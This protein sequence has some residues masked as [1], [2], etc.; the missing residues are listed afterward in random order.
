MSQEAPDFFV[1]EQPP[2]SG[3]PTSVPQ[4][5]PADQFL[6][7]IRKTV[8]NPEIVDLTAAEI[9]KRSRASWREIG[10]RLAEMAN[11]A[12]GQTDRD[13]F[14]GYLDVSL[15]VWELL[16]EAHRKKWQAIVKESI[17]AYAET[18][19]T[20]AAQAMYRFKEERYRINKTV[21]I[22]HRQGVIYDAEKD[23]GPR[24]LDDMLRIFRPEDFNAFG[25]AVERA[26]HGRSTISF[27]DLRNPEAAGN[28]KTT[29]GDD[30]KKTGKRTNG[31]TIAA[32]PDEA[33]SA[34]AESFVE[35]GLLTWTKTDGL[36]RVKS[37]EFMALDFSS[38]YAVQ[39]ASNVLTGEEEPPVKNRIRSLDDL[40]RTYK[41]NREA[42][43]VPELAM[44]LPDWRRRVMYLADFLIGNKDMDAE[45]L[46]RILSN[47]KDL[48]DDKRPHLVVVS[49]LMA[50]GFQFFEKAKRRTLAGDFS[51]VDNQFQAAR[52]VIE[53]IR[54]SGIPAVYVL[55]SEDEGIIQNYTVEAIRMLDNLG[56][57]RKDSEKGRLSWAGIDQLK[58]HK[59][60][61]VHE[62]F[63]RE[64]VF[65]YC[66]RSGRRLRSAD[67]VERLTKGALR[68]EEYLILYKT[69][70]L[71]E[72]G[73]TVP[74]H[75]QQILE[76][77]NIPVSGREFT[78]FLILDGMNLRTKTYKGEYDTVFRHRLNFSDVPVYS[79]PTQVLEWL[80]KN[81]MSEGKHVSETV[82]AHQSFVFGAG[83][84]PGEWAVSLGS[85]LCP[86]I[87]QKQSSFNT[88]GERALRL[89][90]TARRA[91]E[92]AV[93]HHEILD[94]GRYRI[95]F[96]SPKLMEKAASLTDRTTFVVTSDWQIGSETARPDLQVMLLNIIADR[97]LPR[98][99]V[100]WQVNGDKI[101][102]H[103]YKGFHIESRGSG[104]ISVENQQLFLDEILHRFLDHVLP[105]NRK[106]LKRVGITPGNHELNSGHQW[107]GTSHSLLIKNFFEGFLGVRN[108]GAVT[109]HEALSTASGE[110]VRT[111]ASF[112]KLGAYGILTQHGI[113]ERAGKGGGDKAPIYQAGQFFNGLMGLSRDIDI[114]V[115][116]HWHVPM[117]A[118]FGGK[119]GLIAPSLASLSDYE[120]KRGYRPSMGVMILRVGGGKPPTAEFWSPER[121]LRHKITDGYFSEKNLAKL[122]FKTDPGWD[123]VRHGFANRSLPKSSLQKAVWAIIDGL[124]Y[125]TQSVL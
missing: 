3:E 103:N 29:N 21:L 64:V 78:D 104:L 10:P 74:P 13:L 6:T 107:L 90:T 24:Y 84:Q 66:L 115:F 35:V 87:N 22:K 48:P 99:P 77:D 80:V 69:V 2:Q 63:Q 58:Q 8:D 112:E 124:L 7:W 114:A 120:W 42:I 41:E 56:R 54:Q 100:V 72:Q 40:T 37:R 31:N 23:R 11:L 45:F 116:G 12:A 85:G 105:E 4:A 91:N 123:P 86:D 44:T 34:M 94:D 27:D 110:Y 125:P 33:L 82:M 25:K 121:L 106:N 61:D 55:S 117:Y 51:S 57:A 79:N 122:G 81:M 97:I 119:L 67:E 1:N 93:T 17:F 76:M 36:R 60:W 98:Y 26:F 28:G 89:T 88:P 19:R 59:L 30:A 111:P 71:L 43:R 73:K 108:A 15:K 96:Y 101:Q 46:R 68:V 14:L 62:R 50:G 9:G 92:P 83:F 18:D 47:L 49:G 109:L 32:Y 20:G 65:P 5:A 118:M 95:R 75:F 39:L 38:I 113:L 16:G 70:Q 53:E 52:L 102:G